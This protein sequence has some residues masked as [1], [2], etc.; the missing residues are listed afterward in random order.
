MTYDEK[1][2]HI[3]QCLYEL[4]ETTSIPERIKA[5]DDFLAVGAEVH[6]SLFDIVYQTH[7]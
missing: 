4:K 7:S 2:Q 3:E 6:V 5:I 1:A